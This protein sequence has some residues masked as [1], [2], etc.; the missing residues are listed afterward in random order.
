MLYYR[1]EWTEDDKKLYWSKSQR[2]RLE[3]SDGTAR[4]FSQTE[5]ALL[6]DSHKVDLFQ[7]TISTPSNLAAAGVTVKVFPISSEDD[8]LSWQ[9]K[10]KGEMIIC[11]RDGKVYL[12]YL[13]YWQPFAVRTAQS[14][15]ASTTKTWEAGCFTPTPSYTLRW[16]DLPADLLVPVQLPNNEDVVRE[17]NNVLTERVLGHFLM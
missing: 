7:V 11:Y 5:V 15:F 3:C 2:Q 1:K 9:E 8:T 14:T 17:L 6:T 4:K 16:R 10:T 13:E 12:S